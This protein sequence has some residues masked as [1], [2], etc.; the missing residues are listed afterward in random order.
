MRTPIR[1]ILAALITL[2]TLSHAARPWLL[3]NLKTYGPV[4]P[5]TTVFYYRWNAD[6]VRSQGGHDLYPTATVGNV[7]GSLSVLL[8][9]NIDCTNQSSL[10]QVVMVQ[11]KRNWPS[12]VDVHES[13]LW[14]HFTQTSVYSLIC[15]EIEADNYA[16]GFK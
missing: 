3:V 10:L 8:I 11:E 1:M 9:S 2:A 7:S 5:D 13:S 16:H 15:R 4:Y 12:I 6:H 14:V